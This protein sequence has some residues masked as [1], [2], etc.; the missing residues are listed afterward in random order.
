M[1]SAA[2]RPCDVI[3]S[4]GWTMYVVMPVTDKARQWV[5]DNV[6]VEH[7]QWLGSGFGVE[8]RYIE[9]LMA[10]MRQAGLKVRAW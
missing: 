3:V 4:G 7:W 8:H 1:A 6:Q 2:K 10:G 9:N 5:E